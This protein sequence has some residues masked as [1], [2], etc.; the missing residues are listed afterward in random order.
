[1]AYQIRTCWSFLVYNQHLH[2]SFKLTSHFDI[3]FSIFFFFCRP[4]PFHIRFF[5]HHVRR[6]VCAIIRKI[7]L[8]QLAI[9]IIFL[10]ISFCLLSLSWSNTAKHTTIII[11]ILITFAMDTIYAIHQAANMWSSKH[12]VWVMCILYS[13]AIFYI[14]ILV[15]HV[16]LLKFFLG[17]ASWKYFSF[18]FSFAKYIYLVVFEKKWK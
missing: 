9:K 4:S 10:F 8:S 11:L 2:F 13:L 12:C 17:F 5:F 3:N 6:I 14:C 7:C 16:I 18:F 1:M 15:V